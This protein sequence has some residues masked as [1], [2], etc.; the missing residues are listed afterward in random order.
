MESL[1]EFPAKHAN[2]TV[3]EPAEGGL[4][5]QARTLQAVKAAVEKEFDKQIALLKRKQNA[6][7]PIFRLPVELLVAIFQSVLPSYRDGLET[8]WYPPSRLPSQYTNSLGRLISVCHW[9]SKIILDSP[10]LWTVVSCK[11]QLQPT[12][13]T[14]ALRLSRR[15]PLDVAFSF[16]PI[17][18][19]TLGHCFETLCRESSRWRRLAINYDGLLRHLEFLEEVSA[20]G[21]EDFLLC[22]NPVTADGNAMQPLNIFNGERLPKLRTFGLSGGSIRWELGQLA[23]GALRTIYLDLIRTHAPS[24][25]QILDVV[26]LSPLLETLSLNLVALVTDNVAEL[27][28]VQPPSMITVTL[29]DLPGAALRQL[30]P[31]IQPP[32]RCVNFIVENTLSMEEAPDFFAP[33]H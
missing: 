33:G 30:V 6:S 27:P 32:S 18:P 9:W 16:G 22:P 17:S 25:T 5:A 12:Y 21:L 31:R 13:V 2:L 29:K 11:N 3:L 28:T 10:A 24:V 4:M 15:M 14:E 1:P 23:G 26:R 8:M 7:L 19:S 20:P